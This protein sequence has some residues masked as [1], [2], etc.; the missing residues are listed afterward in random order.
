MA[1]AGR[2]TTAGSVLA[3]LDSVIASRRLHDPESSYVAGL[4]RA[5]E[6]RVLRKIAEEA[7]EVML[8]AKSGNREQ[9]AEESADLLF[10]LL[11]LLA[12]Y[13]LGLDD[14]QSVLESR[15]GRSGR[16]EKTSSHS[17]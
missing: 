2:D 9:I 8:A 16:M 12:R 17:P 5:E 7:A 13:G 3:R 10:H 6:D 4:L 14:V 11:V 1:D 15:M